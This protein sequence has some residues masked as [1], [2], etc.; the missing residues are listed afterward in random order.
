MAAESFIGLSP[1]F[2]AINY[3][4]CRL[5]SNFGGTHN[6]VCVNLRQFASKK[7]EFLKKVSK[8]AQTILGADLKSQAQ[9]GIF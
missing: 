2:C 3:P 6:T 1:G 8:N 9:R 7:K 5:S 4:R